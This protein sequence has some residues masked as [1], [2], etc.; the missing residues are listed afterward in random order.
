MKEEL[1]ALLSSRMD[2]D[3]YIRTF[4]DIIYNFAAYLDK[5]NSDRT[6]KD[7]NQAFGYLSQR[8]S[9]KSSLA[10]N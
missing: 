2:K 6:L 10:T 4:C 1:L 3:A 5:Q 8:L 9:L 7:L